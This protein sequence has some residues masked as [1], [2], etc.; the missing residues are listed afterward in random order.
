MSKV[1][2]GGQT[3][4]DKAGLDAAFECGIETG[5]WAPKG[6]LIQNASGENVSDPSLANYGLKEF[7][8]PGYPPRTKAN[9][10]DSDGTVWFG[11]DQSPGGRLTINTAKRLGKPFL[12]NP[13][14][15]NLS[16]WILEREIKVLNI[17]GNRLS[18]F[19]PDIYDTTYM[20]LIEAFNQLSPSD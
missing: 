4:A 17:A 16:E 12:I 20:I 8:K 3:G 1:I 7:P 13:T 2:S 10:Q 11:F 15:P 9:I 14:A 5:G 18:S 19:N 6:W